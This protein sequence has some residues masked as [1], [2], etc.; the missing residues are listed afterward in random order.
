MME[1]NFFAFL[2]IWLKCHFKILPICG[3]IVIGYYKKGEVSGSFLLRI[4]GIGIAE[5][6][7]DVFFLER[8]YPGRLFKQF[9]W[10]KQV[11]GIWDLPFIK[12]FIDMAL[13]GKILVG[14]A[15]KELAVLFFLQFP[16]R[17]G[18]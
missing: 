6:R 4:Q 8:F 10:Q 7:Q 15:K 11:A 16:T 13:G 1:K 18:N 17:S 14:K 2:P 9:Y 5:D 3:E 12:A